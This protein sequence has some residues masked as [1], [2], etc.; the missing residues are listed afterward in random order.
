MFRAIGTDDP[1]A[2][3]SIVDFTSCRRKSTCST[4]RCSC[5]E[6]GLP[7]EYTDP[8]VADKV[9]DNN[10]DVSKCDNKS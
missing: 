5:N 2:M 6:G 9:R 10:V 7:F 4:R 3:N 1:I 8:A